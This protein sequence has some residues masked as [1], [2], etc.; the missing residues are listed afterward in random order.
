MIMIGL[1][2]IS[3][4]QLMAWKRRELHVEA[5]YH[6]GVLLVFM[7]TVGFGEGV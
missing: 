2:L 3:L 6:I 4:G 5:F 7:C 1:E